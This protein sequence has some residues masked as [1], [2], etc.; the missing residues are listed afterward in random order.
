MRLHIEIL[1]S[2]TEQ[3]MAHALPLTPLV[4]IKIQHTQGSNFKDTAVGSAVKQLFGAQL[5]NTQRR[6]TVGCNEQHVVGIVGQ[7]LG[8][9]NDRTQTLGGG[10]GLTHGIDNGGNFLY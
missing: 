2:K 1:Q 3:S 8:V 5:N 9:G 7:T 6:G 10:T 4:D